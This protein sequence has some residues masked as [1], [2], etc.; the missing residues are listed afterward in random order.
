MVEEHVPKLVETIT[1]HIETLT[2][3]QRLK[4]AMLY[5]IN[6]GG[7]RIRPLLLIA[8]AGSY[9][10]VTN[11]AY[12][13]GAAVEMVHTYSL[14]HDDLPSMDDDDI[15]RGKLTN[16]KVYGEA[17][18]ILAGDALLTESFSLITDISEQDLAPRDAL[19][20]SSR[21]SEASGALGMVGG[22]VDDLAA[23][24]CSLTLD[25]LESIHRRKTGA[26]LAFAVEAGGLVGT[27]PK[28]DLTHLR[29]FAEEIGVAFQIKDDILDV[30]GDESAIG[31]PIGSDVDNKKS[32]YPSLL[33]ITEAKRK[34]RN[35]IEAAENALKSLSVPAPA[36]FSVLSYIE[37]R[38]R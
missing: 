5:S 9:G 33:S 10:S 25:E 27:S 1:T 32:T 18:A 38:D 37:L 8:T 28:E 13:L 4:E 16:H 17:M 35:H 24:N 3:P 21:L 36:L 22:Q 2:A 12:K 31:K 29:K 6:A 7:K 19:F 26:L 34:L 14:I 11:A 20:L 15:R 23:E 30:E